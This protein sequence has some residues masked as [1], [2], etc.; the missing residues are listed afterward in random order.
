MM[1]G[2]HSRIPETCCFMDW[3][4]STRMI[5]ERTMH[6]MFLLSLE[7][8]VGEEVGAGE[9]LESTVGAN[10]KAVG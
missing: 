4:V 7:K 1:L 8:P 5:W 10:G 6:L 9:A 3:C 2:R